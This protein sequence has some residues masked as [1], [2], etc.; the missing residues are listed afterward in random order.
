M[1]VQSKPK[2]PALHT[3]QWRLSAVVSKRVEIDQVLLLNANVRRKPAQA[4]GP[5]NIAMSRRVTSK[6]DSSENKL[7]VEV[8]L[9]LVATSKTPEIEEKPGEVLNIGATFLLSY[10]LD[11]RDGIE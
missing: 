6:L 4:A 11:S 5:C 7:H 8:Q 10:L 2:P 1:T 3:E 9:G